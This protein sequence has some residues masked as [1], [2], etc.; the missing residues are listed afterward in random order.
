MDTATPANGCSGGTGSVLT[1]AGQYE[2]KLGDLL[3]QSPFGEGQDLTM[4]LYGMWNKVTS[5]DIYAN[6]NSKLKVGTDFFF[7]AFPVLAFATRFDYLA[8]NSRYKNQ[9]F[10]ILSPRIVFRSQMVTHEQITIQYSRYM[11]SKRECTNGTPADVQDTAG[12]TNPT[13]T[14]TGGL[15]YP[16]VPGLAEGANGAFPAATAGELECVQPPPSP[17]S[18]DGWGSTTET[19]E[20]RLRAAPYTGAHLRPDVNVITV[21]AS[22][23]W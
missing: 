21:E 22:M 4:K 9:N 2:A 19:Q 10:M 16:A 7:D 5:N 3:G 23:W 18:P 20:P 1:L 6:G 13:T 11:Y 15:T 8:P 12:R 14:P 17:N